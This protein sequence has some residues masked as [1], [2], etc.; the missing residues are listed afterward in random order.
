MT[1]YCP[2]LIVIIT[3]SRARGNGNDSRSVI[4][5][6]KRRK[7]RPVI[8]AGAFAWRTRYTRELYRVASALY[9]AT[10]EA[11][12]KLGIDSKGTRGYNEIEAIDESKATTHES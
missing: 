1:A 12:M 5:E 10:R 8:Y 4:S 7:E 11:G 6:D 3:K 2:P 9:R